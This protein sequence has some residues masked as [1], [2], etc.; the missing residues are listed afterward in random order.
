VCICRYDGNKW[1]ACIQYNLASNIIID[2]TFEA[3][4]KM[5]FNIIQLFNIII[6]CIVC[7]MWNVCEASIIKQ[8]SNILCHLLNV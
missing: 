2:D 5:I 4:L 8:K 7:V 1:E 6:Q 3:I